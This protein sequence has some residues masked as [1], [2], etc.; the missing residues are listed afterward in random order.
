[1]DELRKDPMMTYLLDATLRG[2]DI[3]HYG[4]LVVVMVGRHF[5][6]REALVSAIA[7][8]ECD[9]PAARALIDQVELADYSPPKRAKILTTRNVRSSRSFPTR[10]IR[11]PATS[12]GRCS[13]RSTSTNTSANTA[14]PRP[15]RAAERYGRSVT[16]AFPTILRA[17]R[18]SIASAA[19]SSGYR[20]VTIGRS[21]PLAWSSASAR[22]FARLCAG[23][24]IAKTPK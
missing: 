8:G 3:G 21:A 22:K 5:L 20:A 4:R 24:R 16:I 23:S 2:E 13:F 18:S 9:G 19:R 10:A 17:A 14:K 7:H 1:M 15:R 6:D 12:T 11:V